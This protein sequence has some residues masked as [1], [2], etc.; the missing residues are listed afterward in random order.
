MNE[1]S[2]P[3]E[4]LEADVV[5]IGYGGAGATAAITA[6]DSGADVI[7]LEKMPAGGG[8]T[9]VS[10]SSWFC[11]P[12]GMESQ[13]VEHIDALCL[14]RTDRAVIEAY[15]DAARQNKTW[16]ES[17]GATGKVTHFLSVR[18]PQVTHPSWPNFPGSAAMVNQTVPAELDGE[19]VGERLWRLLSGNVEKRGIRTFTGTPARELMTNDRG[20]VVGAIAERD[21]Q[22]ISV[23]AR[24]AVIL[25]S[26]GFEFNESMKEQYLPIMPFYGIGSPGN[27]GD[28]ITMAQK[29]GAQLWHMG[30]AVGGFGLRTEEAEAPFV[31]SFAAP[32][33]IYVNKYGK[34]FTNETGWE[35][36]FAW[37]ALSFFDPKSPGFPTLPIYAVCDKETLRKGSLSV[38]GLGYGLTYKW[39]ADNSAE[40][41]KGWIKQGKTIGELAKQISVDEAVLEKT[42]SRYNDFCK[43]GADTH[44]HR[45]R[46]TLQ[47]L[48]TPPY[49]AIEL[50][51]WMVNT[52]GG[53]RRDFKA[54]VLN[55]EGKPISRLY[56]A[57]ELG[58]LWGHLYCGGGNVGE[59][60]AVGR[61]AGSNAAAEVPWR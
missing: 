26:G 13:A 30:V 5:V 9:R 36:H 3:T 55:T 37:Q 40:V 41:A 61:I 24:R 34:R 51:P 33:F 8:N 35:T 22:K 32:G 27:T 12:E 48:V 23:R 60:L 52:M 50:W 43:T 54:R 21:G 53:P 44:F 1:L 57:G 28:G 20:E 59:A 31:I 4:E 19:R 16:I 6:H 14:G 10:M 56:S 17:L 46:E 11:P 38:G 58:S 42:I 7:I 29:V 47:G 15:V 45:A 39:S 25:T 18:Y 2:R 49:Y